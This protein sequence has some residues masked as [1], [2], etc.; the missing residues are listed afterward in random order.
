MRID[1]PAILVV[2][3]MVCA[4]PARAQTV[5]VDNPPLPRFVPPAVQDRIAQQNTAT[6]SVAGETRKA[7]ELL[8]A[9]FSGDAPSMPDSAGTEAS[10]SEAA[11]PPVADP[12]TRSPTASGHVVVLRTGK[13]VPAAKRKP[14][15][16]RVAGAASSNTAAAEATDPPKYPRAK[17]RSR[18]SGAS[19]RTS[20]NSYGRRDAP[21]SPTA[22]GAEIGWQT[23]LIGM[24]TNPA[25]W[26]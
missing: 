17:P 21:N 12:Q 19:N 4:P 2:C 20:I 24:L 3:A 23:G 22:P 26:H 5:P 14:K 8:S 16:V 15:T 25:F 1:A 11:S 13:S 7:A 18:R 9:R 6:A 10:G